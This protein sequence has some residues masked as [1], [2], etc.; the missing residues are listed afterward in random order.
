M[1][2]MVNIKHNRQCWRHAAQMGVAKP[3]FL[4]CVEA[5]QILIE[6]VKLSLGSI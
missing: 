6:N 3:D 2:S 1:T 4:T 5:D